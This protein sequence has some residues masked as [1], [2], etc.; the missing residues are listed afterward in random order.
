MCRTPRG[1]WAR[2]PCPAC[3]ASPARLGTA[4]R[5]RRRIWPHLQVC[6]SSRRRARAPRAPS[7]RPMPLAAR[8]ASACESWSLLRAGSVLTG[9]TGL[10]GSERSRLGYA[11][12][13]AHPTLAVRPAAPL[14]G[15]AWRPAPRAWRRASRA[16]GRSWC[17][18]SHAFSNT[19]SSSLWRAAGA[20]NPRRGAAGLGRSVG[21]FWTRRG[22]GGF[23]RLAWCTRR[24]RQPTRT[25][26]MRALSPRGPAAWPH[27][28]FP[29]AARHWVERRS[30]GLPFR[31]LPLSC[32]T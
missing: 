30:R 31:G 14:R 10:E 29:S 2:R 7:G 17:A 8:R 3:P 16:T 6:A 15:P 5:A 4:S 24:R 22:L 13:R 23:G 1:T 20:S 21:G 9:L 11:G 25:G 19:A 26:G 27:A 18:N 28:R 32:M 12:L